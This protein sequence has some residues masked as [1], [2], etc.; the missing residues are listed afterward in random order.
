[1]EQGSERLGTLD[2]LL[3]SGAQTGALVCEAERINYPREAKSFHDDL[4]N[5]IVPRVSN[6]AGGIEGLDLLPSSI[7]L[8]DIQDRIAGAAGPVVASAS[9]LN[10]ALSSALSNYDAV[11][12]DCPPSLNV[13]TFNGFWI[14]DF[15]LIPVIPD[16]LSTWGLPQVLGRIERFNRDTDKTLTPLG[17]V[18]NMRRPTNLHREISRRLRSGEMKGIARE[19]VF[20]HEVPHTV[21]AELSVPLN[22]D[23]DESWNQ[24]GTLN[25]KYGYGSPQL[26]AIYQ[27]I[28][29]EFIHR[30][31]TL[32][33]RR[34]L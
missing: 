29:N 28:T 32:K 22:P 24:F 31:N 3:E 6:V 26:Y 13:V 8:I 4:R 2:V 10:Q 20:G 18:I 7:R 16:Y 21:K 33:G 23:D 19:L 12:I 27:E 34:V 1:M 25:Q 11:L 15:C 17:I 5:A 30:C 9:F 14:S